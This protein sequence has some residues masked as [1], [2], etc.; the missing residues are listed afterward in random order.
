MPESQIDGLIE[1]AEV[2]ACHG[3]G[4]R[5]SQLSIPNPSAGRLHVDHDHATNRYRGLLC[6]KCNSILGLAD[7]NTEV[8]MGLIAYLLRNED[9]LDLALAGGQ[10]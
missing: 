3:C 5:A 10:V 9:A 1:E 8:L 2:G 7:D 6:Q 4:K